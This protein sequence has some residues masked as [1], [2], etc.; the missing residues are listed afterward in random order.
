MPGEPPGSPR[1]LHWSAFADKTLPRLPRDPSL[2]RFPDTALRAGVDC[3]PVG[4]DSGFKRFGL[5]S[6]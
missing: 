6:P 5:G 1:P 4:I 2:V 3:V